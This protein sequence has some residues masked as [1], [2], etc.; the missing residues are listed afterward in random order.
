M[1]ASKMESKIKNVM[2]DD[3][4]HQP[5]TRGQHTG[6][7]GKQTNTMLQNHQEQPNRENR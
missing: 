5:G 4:G 7:A 1:P 2:H 6:L 3:D